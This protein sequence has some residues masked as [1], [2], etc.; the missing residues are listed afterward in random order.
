MTERRGCLGDE[1]IGRVALREVGGDGEHTNAAVPG[2]IA[3]GVGIRP[4]AGM[5]RD[6]GAGFRQ[7]PRHCGAEPA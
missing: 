1:A 4:L 3:R 5:K 6:I 2:E 7:R